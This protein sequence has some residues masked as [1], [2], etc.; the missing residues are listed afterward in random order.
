VVI[1]SGSGMTEMATVGETIASATEATLMS[2]IVSTISGSSGE[3]SLLGVGSFGVE[4]E[5][6]LVLQRLKILGPVGSEAE[7]ARSLALLLFVVVVDCVLVLV[8]AGLLELEGGEVAHILVESRG[9]LKELR[10]VLSLV[11]A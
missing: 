2:V 11:L 8:E 10:I 4:T 1:N 7:S 5:E 6:L 3:R 9:E